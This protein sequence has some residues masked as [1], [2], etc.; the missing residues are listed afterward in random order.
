MKKLSQKFDEPNQLYYKSKT[1]AWYLIVLIILYTYT[2]FYCSF[3]IIS[4][5]IAEKPETLFPYNYVCI[6]DSNDDEFFDKIKKKYGAEILSYPM[7]RVANVDKTE[8]MEGRG[9]K[10][11]QGQQIG[12][13]ETTYHKLKKNI[14]KNY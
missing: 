6:A 9:E 2:M 11:A 5:K 3:Q 14:V 13:S 10:R 7:V 1:T 8:R 12:I 4:V